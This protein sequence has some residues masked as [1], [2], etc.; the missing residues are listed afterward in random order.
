MWKIILMSP[1]NRIP[2]VRRRPEKRAMPDQSVARTKARILICED[3]VMLAKQLARSLKNLGYEVFGRV[4]S[5]EDAVPAVEESKPDLILMDINLPGKIDT[6]ALAGATRSRFDVPV[7]YLTGFSEKDVLERARKTEAYGCLSKS[8]SLLELS[9]TIETALYKHEA[10]KRLKE[11]EERYRELILNVYDVVYR[12]D[13]EGRITF[14]SPS[15]ERVFGYAPSEITGKKITDFYLKPD[16]RDH[17]IRLIGK[18]GV[19]KGFEAAITAKKGNTVWVSTN[20]KLQKD[21]SGKVVGIEGVTR[22]ITDRKKAERLVKEIDT[23]YRGLFDESIAAV[24]VF[25][26]QKKF[27]DSNQAGLDLLGYSRDELLQMSIPEV[28]ADP[29]IVLPAHKRLLSGKRIINYEH[30]LKRKDGSIITVL[31]NSRAITDASGHVVGMQSTLIDITQR[32]QAEEDLRKAHEQLERRVEKRTAELARSNE[33]LLQEVT[34]RKSAEEA[35]RRSEELYRGLVE[36]TDTGYVIID[37]MGRVLDAN[38]EYIRLT[39]N[40]NLEEI[41]GRSVIEW[42]AEHDKEINAA[43]VKKCF[44][45]GFVRNLEIDYVDRSG[46]FTPIELNATLIDRIDSQKIVTL[47]RDISDRRKSEDALKESESLLR[48]ILAASAVGI[49]LAENR[50]IGWANESMVRIF[51]YESAPQDEFIGKSSE[52]LYSTKEEFERVGKKM[53]ENYRLGKE[54]ATDAVFKRRDG[55]VFH[56]HIKMSAPDPEHPMKGTVVTVFDITERK[57]AE[58]SLKASEEHLRLITDN[59]PA[60]IS[61]VGADQRYVSVNL[62]YEKAFGLKREEIVGRTVKD[63]LG[64]SGY[65]VARKHIRAALAG[66]HVTYEESFMFEDHQRWLSVSYVPDA[67]DRGHVRGFFTL[68]TD[69]TD[70]KEAEEALQDSEERYR[71]LFESTGL[72]ISQYDREG[73]CLMMNPTVAEYFGGKRLDYE[74]K[75][76]RDLHSEA[77]TDYISRVRDVIETGS[78]KEYEDL[79]EFPTGPRWLFLEV[80]PIQ[81]PGQEEKAAQI[82]SIDITKR[83]R[84]QESLRESEEKF[85]RLFELSYD[86]MVLRDEDGIL[87]CNDACTAMLGFSK[88]EEL[89]SLQPEDFSPEFQPDGRPSAAKAKHMIQMALEKG[90]NRFEW[91]HQK[92]MAHLFTRIYS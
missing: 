80:R 33:R 8:A 19:V 59:V 13:S 23:K 71:H 4:A 58:H 61:Y 83:K 62:E 46:K 50:T 16:D 79:V 15:V 30:Q 91:L 37:G 82:L 43:E 40:K 85:R 74:G 45:T 17:F 67:D 76:F 92:L 6:I 3:E 47:C 66:K 18:E 49:G 5:A 89:V 72:L 68:V 55:S 35:L 42:T 34:D 41:L 12:A 73:Q 63:V 20:A 39:G 56:G 54:G 28:D 64:E 65:G 77:A 69:L 14:I 53:Y 75:N 27:I 22:D 86:A 90:S 31:N 70:R 52:I 51:G 32:K 38:A 7:I 1:E 60:L 25:D 10:D 36:T 9:I 88:R 2:T 44:E 48:N 29:K 81:I 24:Y 57:K 84:A 21:R 78:C 26:A 87:E 11:S